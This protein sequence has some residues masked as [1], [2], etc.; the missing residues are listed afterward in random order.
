[1]TVKV[2]SKE[3]F[4]VAI[5]SDAYQ[6]LINQTLGDPAIAQRFTSSIMS[7]VAINPMLSECDTGSILT[8]GL[9]GEALKLS[10]SPQMGHFY[11]VPFNNKKLGIKQ[12]QFQLGYKGYIQ[13]AIRSGQYKKINVVAVK[14]GELIGFDPFE[15]KINVSA[16]K[17]PLER[18]KA[19]T[20]GYYAFF[21]TN[22][23]FKKEMYWSKEQM[24]SHADTYSQAFSLNDYHKLLKG[25]IKQADM[26]KYSSFWFKDFDGMAFKTMLRQIIS[27]WGVMSIE[28]EQAYRADMAV[29]GEDGQVDYVDNEKNTDRT[30]TDEVVEQIATT[31]TETIDVEL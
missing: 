12:A 13:L 30:N 3:R 31:E 4:S 8:A 28:M 29:I 11:M 5:N 25:E 9:Q 16:I 17:N 21:E 15:E 7:A 22:N 14:E 23:G 1:M 18:E 27:K 26:W 6:G 24:E 2:Q 20:I 10:P 19:K